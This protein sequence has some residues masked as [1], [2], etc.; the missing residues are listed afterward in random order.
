[1]NEEKRAKV[2]L[3]DLRDPLSLNEKM[4]KSKEKK[5]KGKLGDLKKN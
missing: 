2:Q 4:F 3:D 1:M 5:E